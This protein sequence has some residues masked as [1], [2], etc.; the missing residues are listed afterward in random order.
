MRAVLRLLALIIGGGLIVGVTT[1]TGGSVLA[2]LSGAADPPPPA[3]LADLTVKP[4]DTGAHYSRD[5]WGGDVW[6][7]H[8]N[9]CDTREVVLQRQGEG[10]ETGKG[11]TVVAGRWVSRYTGATITDRDAIDIDHL[12]PLAEAARSGTRSWPAERR[13]RFADDMANLVAVEARV[14]RQKS[15]QDPASWLPER[16]RCGYVHQWVNVKA[17]YRLTVDPDERAA[18]GAVLARCPADRAEG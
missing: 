8:G 13:L 11:C 18:L 3:E 12:V 17:K 7:F 6:G 1:L 15:D 9:G 10:V 14:N 5:A 4:E 16:N 2:L